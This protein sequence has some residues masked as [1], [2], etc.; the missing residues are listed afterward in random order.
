VGELESRLAD[1]SPDRRRLMQELL[2]A[3][4]APRVEQP[5]PSEPVQRERPGEG[6]DPKRSCRAF[7]DDINQSL[8][9]TEFGS[10]SLFLNFGYVPAPDAPPERAVISLPE[11][12][13]NKSSVKLV[14][15]V[16]GGCPLDNR[17][18]LD[19]GCGR[20][21]TATV[22]RQYFKPRRFV[23]M[24]LSGRAVGF[25]HR[26]SGARG[27][28]FV[29]GDAE[30]LPFPDGSIDVA[31]NIESSTSYPNVRNFFKEVFRVLEPG[32][33]FLYTDVLPVQQASDWAGLLQ[34]VGFHLAEDRDISR[35]VMLSCDAVARH[36]M[37][38]YQP[39]SNAMMN[40]FLGTPGS[41]VYEEMKSGR[42]TYRIMHLR[43]AAR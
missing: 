31:I 24:D 21:G 39:G 33:D 15:E 5:V 12:V 32:G 43:K 29:Q 25:S 7:F 34:G 14:I 18:V 4:S 42:W 8:D 2:R 3:R 30:N 27:M 41:H 10:F 16:I 40:N 11:H 23:G 37:Q 19:I 26:H 13:L 28:H 17:R 36:R 1:L 38:A 9:S 22:V 20:G 35:N 6:V